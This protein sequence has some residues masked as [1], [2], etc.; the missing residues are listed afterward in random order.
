MILPVHRL[1]VSFFGGRGGGGGEWIGMGRGCSIIEILTT[2]HSVI[3]VQAQFL[4]FSHRAAQLLNS[5]LKHVFT[6][7]K[8]SYGSAV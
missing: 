1:C 7:K 6:P 5:I 4:R 8:R 3:S 2:C